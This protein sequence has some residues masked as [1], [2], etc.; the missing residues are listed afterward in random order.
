MS[1]YEEIENNRKT[2]KTDSYNMSIGELISLYEGQ[3]LDIHPEFQRF[4]R[5]NPNQKSNF[6]ESILLG[7]PIPPIFVNQR[8]DGVWDVID[9]LQRLSTIFQLV[10][11]YKDESGNLLDPLV[12][13]KTK[14][15]PS[16]LGK[17]W[18]DKSNLH[19]SL[20]N[21]E[22]LII[23]RS[24]IGINIILME[25]DDLIKY[26]LFQ[27]LNTGG[28]I[29]SPQEVRNCTMVMI[30]PEF[31]DKVRELANYPSFQNSIA[32]SQNNLEQQYDIE[33]ALRFIIFAFIDLE[34]YD[35]STDVGSYLTDKMVD[36]AKNKSINWDE[37]NVRFQ[38]TFDF[39]YENLGSDAFR[40]YA[41]DKFIGGFLLSPFEVIAFGLGFNYP[42]FPS[43]DVF[44][45][46]T[47]KLYENQEYTQF[48]GSG[49]RANTRLPKLIPLGRDL[50]NN[51][52]THS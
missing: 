19:N 11:I 21:D 34:N 28:S 9:G 24:K 44:I 49:V 16:L 10:G 2:I 12:L 15:L 13:E 18:D 22:R 27:R 31:Y 4:F 38:S 37:M 23:K 26:E 3:E 7:I 50:F 14:Y 51:E 6:I 41:N 43:P 17:R 1:L 45:S 40:R 47:K 20:T 32:L 25:S 8:K 5:W 33:L 36:L 52:H 35:R 48:S 29:L 39:I 30:N 46:E 42:N